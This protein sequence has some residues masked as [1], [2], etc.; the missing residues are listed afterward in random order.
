MSAALAHKR[1][2]DPG[3][4]V[5]RIVAGECHVTD[6]AE[7]IGTTLG[8]CISACVRDRRTGV[9]GMNHFM[10]PQTSRDAH[11][12]DL[13]EL[14]YGVHAMEYLVNEVLRRCGERRSDLEVKLVG[15]GELLGLGPGVGLRN[16]E[17]VHRFLEDAG[18]AVAAADLGGPHGRV[19]RYLP[20][21]GQLFVR[22]LSGG[23]ARSVVALE[24]D[25]RER[26]AARRPRQDA[27]ELF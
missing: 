17:F 13:Q 4:R 27:V 10:L 5:V 25:Y 8:S 18:I 1:V 20:S 19:V 22:A 14:R 6:A 12:A 24:Q 26:I 23:R 11:E 21:T 16:R 9:G 15:G 3:Q 7:L 2:P